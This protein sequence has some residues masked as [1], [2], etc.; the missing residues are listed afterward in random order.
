MSCGVPKGVVERDWEDE[1]GVCE[2]CNGERG[3]RL[4]VRTRRIASVC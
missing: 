2:E 3:K 4:L 1:D